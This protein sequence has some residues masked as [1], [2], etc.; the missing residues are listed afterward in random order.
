MDRRE[1]LAVNLFNIAENYRKISAY[2]KL[3]KLSALCSAVVKSNAYGL[4]LYEVSKVLYSA[5][6]RVFWV[7]YLEEALRL[8]KFLDAKIYIF[9]GVEHQSEIEEFITHNFIPVISNLEQLDILEQSKK[10]KSVRLKVALNFDVGIG[11]DGLSLDAVNNINHSIF[12]IDHVFGHLSCSEEK[13]SRYNLLQLNNLKKITSYFPNSTFSLASSGGLFLGEDYYFDMLRIGGLLYG[14]SIAPDKL[15]TLHTAE[16]YS[17][18]VG[19]K[20]INGDSPIGYDATYMSKKGDRILIADIGYYNGYLSVLGNKSQVYAQGCFMPV[21]GK[22]SMNMIAIDANNLP[23]DVFHQIKTVELIG[24][25]INLNQVA[26]WANVNPRE[27]LT[28]IG[29]GNEKKYYN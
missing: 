4:G 11:R 5:G 17:N 6:C 21:I 22:V 20:V 14:V 29:A 1:F 2:I 16:L 3:K 23:I 24:E 15:Q 26:K 8:K 25:N 18:I 10:S 9:R 12:E 13:N 7:N 19:R 27:L 28:L